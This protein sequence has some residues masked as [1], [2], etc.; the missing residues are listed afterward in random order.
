[1]KENETMQHVHFPKVPSFAGTQPSWTAGTHH[2]E[3]SKKSP[4]LTPEM[5]KHWRSNLGDGSSTIVVDLVVRL[6]YDVE[7]HRFSA[8][9]SFTRNSSKLTIDL[10]AAKV[11][12]H[13]KANHLKMYLL[14]QMV[15]SHCHVSFRGDINR[16]IDINSFANQK[17]YI[18]SDKNYPDVFL[19]LAS[20][21]YN[22]DYPDSTPWTF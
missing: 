1:M 12:W 22:M 13:W 8:R 15:L 17:W 19:K 21:W 4:V 14:L 18:K 20:G 6:P 2:C 16:Y 11:R 7:I 5:P 10:H 9:F 3:K